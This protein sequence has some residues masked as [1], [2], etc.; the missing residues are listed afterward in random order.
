MEASV[1]E[2]MIVRVVSDPE[3]RPQLLAALLDSRIAV[4]LDRGLENGALP[5][6]FKPL[7]LNA[8]QGFPVLA[9]FTTREK[10]APWIEQQPAFQHV[11]VTGFDWAVRITRP[12]FG[13]A[14]NPGY[15][16]SFALSPTE[17]EALA[18]TLRNAS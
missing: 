6:D 10:A 4:P 2:E 18:E 8:Q 15:K 17:V 7:T 1:L 13:I 9:V 12:P 14:I 3:T 16:Y 5:A 11:L